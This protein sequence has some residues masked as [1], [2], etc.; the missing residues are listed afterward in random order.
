[1]S[2]ELIRKALDIEEKA[3]ASYFHSIGVLRLLKH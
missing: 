2:Y 1:M 3:T